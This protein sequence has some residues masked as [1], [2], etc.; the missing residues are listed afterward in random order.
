VGPLWLFI[1]RS[2]TGFSP[3]LIFSVPYL[4]YTLRLLLSCSYVRFLKPSPKVTG[5]ESEHLGGILRVI[6]RRVKDAEKDVNEPRV[7]LVELLDLLISRG[8]PRRSDFG[9]YLPVG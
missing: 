5:I 8:R 7:V 6:G 9:L 4:L 2:V 1:L 3:F